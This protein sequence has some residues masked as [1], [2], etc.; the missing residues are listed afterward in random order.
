MFIFIS[1]PKKILD[2]FSIVLDNNALFIE[3]QK[4]ETIHESIIK[5]IYIDTKHDTDTFCNKSVGE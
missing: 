2:L 1:F 3:Q 5:E 4:E